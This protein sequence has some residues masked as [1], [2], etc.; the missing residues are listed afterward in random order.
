MP[1]II[2][3]RIV[4]NYQIIIIASKEIVYIIF[5]LKYIYT[6]FYLYTKAFHLFI[7][8]MAYILTVNEKLLG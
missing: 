1:R 7:W 2:L 6:V 8:L 3:T 5:L 4:A